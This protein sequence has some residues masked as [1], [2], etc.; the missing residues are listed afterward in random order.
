[1]NHTQQRKR[2]PVPPP[3]PR[4]DAPALKRRPLVAMP[5]YALALSWQHAASDRR[6]AHN[7]GVFARLRSAN[8]KTAARMLLL[9]GLIG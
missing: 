8:V 3:P 5:G 1:M 4:I 9:A 6:D 2:G 7:M